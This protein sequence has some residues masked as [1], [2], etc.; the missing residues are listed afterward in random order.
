MVERSTTDSIATNATLTQLEPLPTSTMSSDSSDQN[1]SESSENAESEGSTATTST[2]SHGATS[3]TASSTSLTSSASVPSGKTAIVYTRS[4]VFTA[5][6]TTFTTALPLTTTLA[7]KKASTFSA[8][9]AAV[10]TDVSFYQSW[11]SGTLG[12][13]SSGQGSMT[14]GHRN[15]IIGS[16]VGGVCG[17]ILAATFIWFLVF[18]RG[19]RRATKNQNFSHEIGTRLEYPPISPSTDQPRSPDED[20]MFLKSKYKSLGGKLPLWQ[21]NNTNLQTKEVARGA[22]QQQKPRGNPFQD[23][24]DFQNRRLPPPPPPPARSTE[25]P[26]PRADFYESDASSSSGSSVDDSTS[27]IQ[28]TRPAGAARSTQ[29]FLQEVL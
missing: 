24:F 8:P 19:K 5:S 2:T 1:S 27:S 14:P 9:T 16:V 29:S 12:S 13:T 21:G 22:P 15:T 6:T 25:T 3:E 23:E 20:E 28:L 26:L 17:F 7:T 4:Y 11:L 18:R 10:T